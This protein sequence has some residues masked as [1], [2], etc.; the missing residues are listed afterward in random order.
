MQTKNP[1]VMFWCENTNVVETLRRDAGTGEPHDTLQVPLGLYPDY[2]HSRHKPEHM[3]WSCLLNQTAARFRESA[4]EILGQ[5]FFQCQPHERPPERQ[6]RSLGYVL[7]A[8][9][10]AFFCLRT[11]YNQRLLL[12]WRLPLL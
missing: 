6:P 10:I 11:L 8:K 12:S 3:C 7:R 1:Q 2:V 5:S 9:A 4:L